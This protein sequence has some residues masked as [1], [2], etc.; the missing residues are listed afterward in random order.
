MFKQLFTLI[1]GRSADSAEAFLDANALPLLRQQIRE[2]AVCV[3][4]SRKALAM[5]MAYAEREKVSLTRIDAK[6]ADLEVRATA[7]L[8]S[9]QLELA[10]E[11]ATTIAHLEAE[12]DATQKTIDTYR[13]EIARLRESL[14]KSQ[15]VLAELTRGQRLAEAN[16]KAQRV[17]GQMATLQSSNLEEASH[18]LRRLQE[19]QAHSDA[20]VAALGELSATSNA[21]TM[22]DRL[23]AAGCG[24]AKQSDADAVLARLK[25]KKY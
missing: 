16:D 20:T 22:S 24:P 25:S 19:R 23:A 6:I 21:T 9:D 12:R 10:T 4:K 3:D 5:V 2:A 7:A 13:V 1:R 8:D 17:K 15:G 14:S 18:T 11:A